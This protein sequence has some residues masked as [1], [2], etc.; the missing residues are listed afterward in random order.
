MYMPH[1]QDS[2]TAAGGMPGLPGSVPTLKD[3]NAAR[4]VKVNIASKAKRQTAHVLSS[5]SMHVCAGTDRPSLNG[6]VCSQ[7]RLLA[8]HALKCHGKRSPR[9]HCSCSSSAS[10]SEGSLEDVQFHNHHT[11]HTTRCIHPAT[12]ALKRAFK[13]YQNRRLR[14][15]EC[16]QAATDACGRSAPSRYSKS[17]G[18]C[19]LQ[20]A[21]EH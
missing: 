4:T 21:F 1:V 3:Y 19:C 5:T 7:A 8:T 16:A 17:T 9:W 20:P 14:D 15:L 13:R 12:R 2:T 10:T 6:H 18:Q 11:V